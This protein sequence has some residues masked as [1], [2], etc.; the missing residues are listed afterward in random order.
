MAK[1]RDKK[2]S[3]PFVMLTWELLNSPAYKVLTPSAAK[4]L[5]F[6][7]GKSG[8]AILKTGETVPPFE[9]TYKEALRLGFARRTYANVIGE[10]VGKGFVDPYQY[11]G[12]RGFC[13][14]CNKFC[15][16]DRWKRYGMDDFN[17]KSWARS[18]E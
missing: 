2:K 6:F 12:L 13:K 10:L 7:L 15:W 18:E 11:G 5:P 14:S 4:A 9:F 17:R 3:S 8:K 1:G 16:S